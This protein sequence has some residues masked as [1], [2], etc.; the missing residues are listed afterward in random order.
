[1]LQIFA[2]I[3]GTSVMNF[4]TNPQHDF[5][6]M[7]GGVKGRLELFRKFI[8]F[9]RGRLPLP[10]LPPPSDHQQDHH[11]GHHYNSRSCS[12]CPP[13]MKVSSFKSQHKTGEK[14]EHK[15]TLKQN[16]RH[17]HNTQIHLH[18]NTNTDVCTH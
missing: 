9:G 13:H 6:K 10:F 3:K 12:P 16:N 1:M 8:R 11:P 18:V 14:S 5:P 17:K 2:I 4:G 15:H 7:R